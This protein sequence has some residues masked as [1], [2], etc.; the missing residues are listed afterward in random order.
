MTASPSII[1]AVEAVWRIPRPGSNNLLADPSFGA[2][3][4]LC[5]A[6]YGGGKPVFAL[7]AALRSLGLPCHLPSDRA[8]LALDPASAANAIDSAYMRTTA[9]RRHLC[10]LDLADDL[11]ALHFGTARVEQFSADELAKLFDAP[12]LARNFH[13]QPLDAERLSHTSPC[14][15][16]S[17]TEWMRSWRI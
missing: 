16:F 11:P 8:D 1:A 7:S 17:P 15:P 3:T 10:P 5:Q 6:E 9:R 2:L 12:R 14:G 13:N 4:E